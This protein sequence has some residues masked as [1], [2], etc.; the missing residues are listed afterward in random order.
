MAKRFIKIY[1]QIVDWEWFR[2]P[3]TVSLFIYL[4]V[5]ANY[6]DIE[7]HGRVIKRG[8][9]LTSLPKIA[10]GTGLTI[11]QTRT[12]INRLISTGELTDESSNQ[13]RIITIVKYDQ[14]QNATGKPTGKVLKSDRQLDRQSTD[15]ST[16]SIEY[17]EQYRKDRSI[18]GKFIPPTVEEVTAYAKET[19]SSV[20]PGYF[21]D[22]YAA[23]GWTLKG[24]QKMKDWK[25]TFRNWER[26][27]KNGS[28]KPGKDDHGK[29]DQV[30]TELSARIPVF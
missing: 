29:S 19:G 9:L 15:E 1:E 23:V 7:F 24:G 5:K 25:A 17:I 3:D 28:G 30:L 8:Q 13:G 6:K 4:L 26:R 20:D 12:S 2:Y 22:H 18:E 21:F 14:Y 11:R 10:T 27:E 16:P